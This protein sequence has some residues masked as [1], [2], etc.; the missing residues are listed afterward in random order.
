MD[1]INQNL[2][3]VPESPETEKLIPV[4]P[5]NKG[6]LW[7]VIL[8]VSLAVVMV[9]L[10]AFYLLMPSESENDG[11]IKPVTKRTLKVTPTEP[12]ISNSDEITAIEEDLNNTE[13]ASIDTELV[14]MEKELNQ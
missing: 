4:A 11:V 9:F 12:L 14:Q 13:V 6:F 2:S 7:G 8:V 10:L 3:A 1:E 5:S